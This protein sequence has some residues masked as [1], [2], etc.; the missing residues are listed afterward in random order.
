MAAISDFTCV[1]IGVVKQIRANDEIEQGAARRLLLLLL[2]LL[3]L[4]AR[5]DN[6]RDIEFATP[7]QLLNADTT[8]NKNV[9]GNSAQHLLQRTPPPHQPK[10]SC[11]TSA[12][13]ATLSRRRCNVLLQFVSDKAQQQQKIELGERVIGSEHGCRGLAL[14]HRR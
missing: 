1:C 5:I 7:D 3:L 8:L 10:L 4:Q 14:C 9:S 12:F 6:A 13:A 2:L 11:R